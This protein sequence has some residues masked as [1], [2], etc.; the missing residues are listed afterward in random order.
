MTKHLMRPLGRD[1]YP[2][3]A[4]QY[5][6][7][8]TAAWLKAFPESKPKDRDK[9]DWVENAVFIEAFERLGLDYALLDAHK[10]NVWISSAADTLPSGTGPDAFFHTGISGRDHIEGVSY[11]L[12]LQSPSA[13]R[14]VTEYATDKVF[15]DRAGRPMILTR[16]TSADLN[17][18]VRQIVPEGGGIFIKTVKKGAT[19]RFDIVAGR[20]PWEQM[21]EQDE[22]FIWSY[23]QYEGMEVPFFNVQGLIE[24]TY[25]YRMFMV[26]DRPVTGAGCV[27]AF[28]P[29]DNWDVF[30][31]KMEPVRNR[32][33]VITANDVLDAYREFAAEFGKAFAAKHGK[34]LTY[35]LDLCIDKHTGKVVPIELNPPMNLGRYASDIDAWVLAVDALLQQ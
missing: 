7:E 28:T 20:D 30:D 6:P 16:P 35:S 15:L 27:E 4:E 1:S 19:Y 11:R 34:S 26:G 10:G 3:G 17:D 22:N 21:A 24:P 13:I 2:T 31:P 33:G 32:T 23:M 25:E 29:L 14:S 9:E 5:A 18:A 8:I 12:P